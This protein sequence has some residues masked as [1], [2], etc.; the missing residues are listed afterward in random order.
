MNRSETPHELHDAPEVTAFLDAM[1]TRLAND[2]ATPDGRHS[3]SCTLIACDLARKFLA[4]GKRPYLISIHGELDKPLRPVRYEG[5]VTWGGHV[6]CG[7]DGFIYD[8]MVGHPIAEEAYA[9]EAFGR[10]VAMTISVPTDR[11]EEFVAR[12]G[13]SEVLSQK[14]D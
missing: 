6:V 4:V 2:Y 9:K 13:R 11:I 5:R 8:P 3:E 1:N 10:E 7:C 12:G 14:A